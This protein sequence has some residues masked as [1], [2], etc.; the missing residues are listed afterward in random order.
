[1]IWV[2][3]TAPS[4]LVLWVIS[5]NNLKGE[6]WSV[7]WNSN[8]NQMFYPGWFPLFGW[9]VI[10]AG[11][12]KRPESQP[13]LLLRLYLESWCLGLLDYKMKQQ[14]TFQPSNVP[15]YWA[16]VNKYVYAALQNTFLNVV[17]LPF[18]PLISL[19][20]FLYMLSY[21]LS[22]QTFLI[23]ARIVNTQYVLIISVFVCQ[24]CH[25]IIPQP[26]WLKHQK[27]IFSQF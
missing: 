15:H 14:L 13:D 7:V 27:F 6:G 4:F 22:Y 1:M 5:R 25:N 3:F 19:S 2:L 24:G 16:A 11:T 21:S 23:V 12:G 17:V 26:E 9:E 20:S 18:I 10:V 8:P